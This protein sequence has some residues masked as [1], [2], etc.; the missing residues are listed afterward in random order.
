MGTH[1]AP[2]VPALP[3][4]PAQPLPSS[5]GTVAKRLPQCRTRRLRARVCSSNSPTA[6]GPATRNYLNSRATP[7]ADGIDDGPEECHAD[8]HRPR[9]IAG[10]T[11][12]SSSITW[13]NCSCHW[14]GG[15]HPTHQ[16]QQQR[17]TC[18]PLP[19]ILLFVLL[20]NTPFGRTALDHF[21]TSYSSHQPYP[22]RS[23][24]KSNAEA[25]K[26]KK[27]RN[28]TKKKNN[29]KKIPNLENRNMRKDIK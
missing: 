13:S 26:K 29:K 4:A 17:A 18:N 9:G 24:E 19:T 22:M 12:S 28:K 7:T 8:V 5:T 2:S 11:C 6:R 25:K 3:P 15:Y 10:C 27:K 16:Q 23:C 21:Q 1:S 20:R 14:D